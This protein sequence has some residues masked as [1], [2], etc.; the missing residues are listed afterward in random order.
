MNQFCVQ[1]C[2]S[3]IAQVEYQGQTLYTRILN[4][5]PVID[6]CYRILHRLELKYFHYAQ[7]LL[8]A[9]RAAHQPRADVPDGIMG[10]WSVTQ[11]MC[12]QRQIAQKIFNGKSK[13]EGRPVSTGLYI[14]FK[15]CILLA[16]NL[17]ENF[18]CDQFRIMSDII[19][20]LLRASI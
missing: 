3:R 7:F 1:D 9:R 10:G 8:N 20:K 2:Q 11:K 14:A 15:Y 13:I 19:S 18:G 12:L 17:A 6:I 16:T 4:C 5:K